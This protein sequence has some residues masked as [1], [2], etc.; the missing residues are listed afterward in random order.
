[1]NGLQGSW[2]LILDLDSQVPDVTLRQLQEALWAH[3]LL[4]G[5][6]REMGTFGPVPRA[7]EGH[8]VWQDQLL[9][10][11]TKWEQDGLG[12]PPGWDL[13]V[14]L[15]LNLYGLEQALG[16]QPLLQ[17]ALMELATDLFALYP[18]RLA[19]VGDVTSFYLNADMVNPAW[20]DFQ[21]EAVLALRLRP[22][23]P[24]THSVP[25]QA[26]Q[27][28]I[29]YGPDEMRPFWTSDDASTRYLRY[30]HAISEQLHQP[31][32]PASLLEWERE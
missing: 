1:M 7:C 4:K 3:P 21:Q 10:C 26:E 18:W 20:F 6:R 11:Y 12:Y 15:S 25:G 22:G 16:E 24:L 30:K 5:P 19:L 2:G 27:S 28:W 17:A 29:H 8:L 9:D 32:T 14:V 23:H 31:E 13:P